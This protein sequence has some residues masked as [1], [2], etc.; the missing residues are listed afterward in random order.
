MTILDLGDVDE[1]T[2]QRATLIVQGK[3]RAYDRST[4]LGSVA[5]ALLLPETDRGGASA[6]EVQLLDSLSRAN[7]RGA[8][9]THFTTASV[10]VTDR[11]RRSQGRMRRVPEGPSLADRLLAWYPEVFDEDRSRQEVD[12]L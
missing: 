10:E 1:E 5:I 3:I 7:I 11:D 8:A 9:T 12:G 4:R 2:L 6:I